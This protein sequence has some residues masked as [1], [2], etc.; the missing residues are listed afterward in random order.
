MVVERAEEYKAREEPS[1]EKM[2]VS[3]F[4][5]FTNACG[6]LKSN[7]C[8]LCVCVNYV[9]YSVISLLRDS[10]ESAFVTM[11]IF[12][13]KILVPSKT[14]SKIGGNRRFNGRNLKELDCHFWGETTRI[15]Q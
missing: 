14:M 4:Y 1:R 13:T 11:R 15:N 8:F 7:E 5:H 9:L 6:L 10:G 2:A 12:R 3:P